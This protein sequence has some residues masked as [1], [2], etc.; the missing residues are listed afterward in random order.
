MGR[1][2]VLVRAEEVAF[3]EEAARLRRQCIDVLS[4]AKPQGPLYNAT[5]AIVD[6]IDGLA[7]VV[8][9]NRARFHQ[10]S[11]RTPGP[12][13]PPVKWRTVE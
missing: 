12:D 6:A 7:E 13:L 3:L 4:R 11:P 2:G 8:T 1:R 5:A 9:G 10:A